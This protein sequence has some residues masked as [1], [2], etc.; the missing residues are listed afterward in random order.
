LVNWGG[1][2]YSS[3]EV[4]V[5]SKKIDVI[6]VSIDSDLIIKSWRI[7]GGLKTQG[8]KGNR[9]RVS[10]EDTH[11]NEVFVAVGK[12]CGDEVGIDGVEIGDDAMVEEL[13]EFHG[14]LPAT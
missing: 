2:R 1:R 5:G 3:K 13:I 11:E 7:W 4:V 12:S 8:E 9:P 14:E 6:H 10:L